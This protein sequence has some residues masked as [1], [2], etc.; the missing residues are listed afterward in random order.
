M[1]IYRSKKYTPFIAS[2][3]TL[4][5]ELYGYCSLDDSND[6]SL[7]INDKCIAIVLVMEIDNPDNKKV[8]IN[9]KFEKYYNIINFHTEI[10]NR[11]VINED[12]LNKMFREFQPILESYSSEFQKE[13][14][15]NFIN[16]WKL[17]NNL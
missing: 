17:V 5:D 9:E 10:E 8:F 7:I 13:V 6:T 12:E 1:K 16:N 14:S 15:S 3:S 2:P 4:S 11:E